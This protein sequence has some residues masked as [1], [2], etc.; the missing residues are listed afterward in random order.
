MLTKS[1]FGQTADVGFA[2]RDPT[3]IKDFGILFRL[4]L[5]LVV[6]LVVRISPLY[7]YGRRGC[8]SFSF[9]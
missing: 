3:Y 2:G 6:T 7:R 8:W 4:S 1:R 5:G 9:G